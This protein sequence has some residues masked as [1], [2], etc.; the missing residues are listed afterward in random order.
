MT[1]TTTVVVPFTRYLPEL[2]GLAT[3]LELEPNVDRIIFVDYTDHPP[4]AH[5]VHVGMF[6]DYVTR[7]DP[8]RF[9]VRTETGVTLSDAWN[10]GAALARVHAQIEETD[11][12]VVVFCAPDVLPEPEGIDVLRQALTDGAADVAYAGPPWTPGTDPLTWT[13]EGFDGRL[14]AVAGTAGTG[15]L[16]TSH[17]DHSTREQC[18]LDF[19][20]TLKPEADVVRIDG[21]TR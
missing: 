6:R 12:W 16:L 19:L 9:G 8:V 20:A 5:R 11:G 7:L 3:L 10:I 13:T 17:G 14:F 21:L 18:A 4:V 1:A 2:A 15:L